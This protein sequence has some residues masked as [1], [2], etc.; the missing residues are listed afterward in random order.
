MA[1]IYDKS[2]VLVASGI[3]ISENQQQ[4]LDLGVAISVSFHT[5]QLMRH[6]IGE[7]AGS[8]QLS[9]EN[10]K[11][12]TINAEAVRGYAT[13]FRAITAYQAD[14]QAKHDAN[15]AVVSRQKP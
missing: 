7:Q 5:P 13:L 14:E 2:G 8:F 10:G 12:V 4:L 1:D 3:P 11:I 9:K 6:K 15:M